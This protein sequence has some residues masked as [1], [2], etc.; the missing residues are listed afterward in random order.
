MKYQRVRTA[1]KEKDTT[2]K[3]SFERNG[4]NYPS[5]IFIRVFKEEKELELWAK[6]TKNEWQLFRKYDICS[7]SGEVGPKRQEGDYQVPEGF[8]VLDTFNPWSNFY[9]SMRIN[10]PNK[11]DRKIS[12]AK[13]LGGDIMLHGACV[14]IGCIAITDDFIKE[15]YWLAV[16]AKNNGQSVIPIH[17]FPCRMDEKRYAKLKNDYTEKSTLI[18]FWDNLKEGYQFFEHY[19][20][21]PNVKVDKTGRYLFD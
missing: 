17:I 13:N 1:Q 9:L 3:Q 10:Y 6:N 2:L 18:S 20:K 19:K 5:E 16:L 7:M 15:V 12:T 14:S 4:L 8:Y 21:L 11:S